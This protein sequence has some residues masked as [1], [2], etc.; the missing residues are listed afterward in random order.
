MSWNRWA[1]C[2][3]LKGYT[4]Q[5]AAAKVYTYHGSSRLTGFLWLEGTFPLVLEPSWWHAL[6]TTLP[7]NRQKDR[8]SS[9]LWYHSTG[10]NIILISVTMICCHEL[11]SIFLNV[12]HNNPP[13]WLFNHKNKKRSK[14]IFFLIKIYTLWIGNGW[15][16]QLIPEKKKKNLP[17]S[18]SRSWMFWAVSR[19]LQPG[20]GTFLRNPCTL[21]CTMQDPGH[22]VY[23][24]L[25]HW[26]VGKKLNEPHQS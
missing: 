14:S 22:T 23:C 4:L 26:E 6:H 20:R 24:D 2:C 1:G 11:N 18:S 25:N 9:L 7:V 19:P 12:K 13:M 15:W 10:R 8:V 16:K 17:F 21:K 3:E 5:P